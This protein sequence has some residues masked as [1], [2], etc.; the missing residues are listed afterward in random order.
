[1]Y[2]WQALPE[3]WEEMEFNDFLVERRKRISRVVEDAY[4]KI[5]I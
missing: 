3:N 4:N 2:Y 1:L 5:K